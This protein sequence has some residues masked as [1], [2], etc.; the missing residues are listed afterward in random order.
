MRR[1]DERSDIKSID[2]WMRL[3]IKGIYE[4]NPNNSKA[5][6]NSKVQKSTTAFTKP[7]QLFESLSDILEVVLLELC[8]QIEVECSERS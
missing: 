8:K 3:K 6:T 5:T 2:E 4:N 1:L 7:S